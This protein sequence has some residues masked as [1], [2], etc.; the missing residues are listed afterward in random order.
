MDVGVG[1][2]LLQRTHPVGHSI[3]GRI[4]MIFTEYTYKGVYSV[5]Q[6]DGKIRGYCWWAPLN[7]IQYVISAIIQ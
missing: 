7:N 4:G 3:V 2:G 5:H 6:P 1:K